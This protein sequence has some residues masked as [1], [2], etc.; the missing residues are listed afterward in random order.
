ML[1]ISIYMNESKYARENGTNF[2]QLCIPEKGICFTSHMF[3]KTQKKTSPA[4]INPRCFFSKT[5]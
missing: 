1:G 5:Y 2:D 4:E 3:V